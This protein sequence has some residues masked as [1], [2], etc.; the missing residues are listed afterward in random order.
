MG[1]WVIKTSK[2][3][4]LTRQVFL[5]ALVLL[6]TGKRLREEA[7]LKGIFCVVVKKTPQVWITHMSIL[8]CNLVRRASRETTYF[9]VLLL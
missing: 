3:T 4:L 5:Q 2:Q 1:E 9:G 8:W 6:A 7:T